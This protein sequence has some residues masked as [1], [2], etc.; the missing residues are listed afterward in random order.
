[1]KQ[2]H[3]SLVFKGVEMVDSIAGALIS[4]HLFAVN[5]P[6]TRNIIING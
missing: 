5:S 4:P 6:K 2:E 3:K 1:M